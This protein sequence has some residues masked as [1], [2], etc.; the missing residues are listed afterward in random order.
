VRNVLFANLPVLSL[1]EEIPPADPHL[2][3][4]ESNMQVSPFPEK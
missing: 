1:D 2:K 3:I 4:R